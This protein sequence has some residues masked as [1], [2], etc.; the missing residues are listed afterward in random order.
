M[1]TLKYT[2]ILFIIAFSNCVQGQIGNILT[3]AEY[4][5]MKINGISFAKINSTEGDII[6]MKALFGNNMT[7]KTGIEP[8]LSIDFSDNNKGF[9]F[10]FEENGP[11]DYT[12]NYFT[13]SNKNTNFT[14][15]DKTV[16]IGSDISELGDV[17]IDSRESDISFG[18]NYSSSVLII[19]FDP[20]T[21]KITEIEYIEFT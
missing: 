2:T 15:L 13:I 10:S 12:L 5:D 17:K 11:D 7:I 6:Q 16:T 1:K 20:S 19:K 14:I 18:D 8:S 4:I 3:R 9:Y 21:K